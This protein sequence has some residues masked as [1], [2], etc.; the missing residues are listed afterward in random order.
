MWFSKVTNLRL[1]LQTIYNAKVMK[2]KVV[3]SLAKCKWA[4]QTESMW[5]MNLSFSLKQW[6]FVNWTIT[7]IFLLLYHS[8]LWFTPPTFFKFFILFLFREQKRRKLD[9][10]ILHLEFAA[11]GLEGTLA[12]KRRAAARVRN[13]KLIEVS[14]NLVIGV[15]P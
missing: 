6:E 8:D 7:T 15:Y 2:G 9:R 14:L 10:E 12:D 4:L 5:P 11:Q 13:S 1:F 3:Y